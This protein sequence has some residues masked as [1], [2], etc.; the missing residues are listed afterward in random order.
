MSK[1]PVRAVIVTRLSR[2][3]ENST[4][5]ERQEKDCREKCKAEGWQVVGVAKDVNVSAGRRNPWQREGLREWIGKSKADPGRTDEFDVLVFWRMDRLVRSVTQL[6]E[7]LIWAGE[8][9]VTLVSATEQMFDTTKPEGKLMISMVGAFAELELEAIRERIHADQ[10]HRITAGQ[11]AG[12]V[13]PWGYRPV[14]NEQGEWMLEPD[15]QQVKVINRVVHALLHENKSL[16]AIT[17]EL[18]AEGVPTVRDL[19]NARHGRPMKGYSWST[20]PLTRQLRNPTLLGLVTIAEGV[21]DAHGRP[22]RDKYGNRTYEKGRI[23]LGPDNRPLRRAEPVI[24]KEDFDAVQKVLDA[25]SVKT[26]KS[27]RSS[28]LLLNVLFC[29]CCGDKA[30]LLHRSDGKYASYYRCSSMSHQRGGRRECSPKQISTQADWIEDVVTTAF[31][32]VFGDSVRT[33]RVWHE[34]TDTSNEIEELNESMNSVA[35]VLAR[36]RPGSAAFNSLSHQIDQI[37]ARLDE[38]EAVETTPSGWIWEPTGQ[39]IREWW[40]NASVKERNA[41]LVE[42]GVRAEFEHAGPNQ[43]GINPSVRIS[44]EDFEGVMSTLTPSEPAERLSEAL[45]EVPSSVTMHLH[46]GDASFEQREEEK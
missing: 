42:C 13:P 43:R 19:N 46:N 31:L 3:T 8:H 7:L 10:Q 23:L 38:L 37:Q 39:T 32:G 6:W 44:F 24:S 17:R 4:S 40:E 14:K 2:E 33:V 45:K 15:P 35:G 20:T 22:V 29:G 36:Q 18:N 30:Y 9:G 26:P 41:Y 5:I 28:S 12:G 11:Y 21:Q 25:R 16:K 27:S 1:R 34:G